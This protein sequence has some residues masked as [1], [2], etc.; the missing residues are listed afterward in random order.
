MNETEMMEK[1]LRKVYGDPSTED[2]QKR[3]ETVKA[4]Y[5]K[6][7]PGFATTILDF[8]EKIG[9]DVETAGINKSTIYI[10]ENFLKY[11]PMREMAGI[12]THEL[13]H[14]LLDHF[15]R[16][17]ENFELNNVAGDLAINTLIEDQLKSLLDNDLGIA[18]GWGMFKDFP[19][20]LSMEDY[21]KL[22][23][24]SNLKFE[25]IVVELGPHDGK[26][27]KQI[28]R[29]RIT[30][31]NGNTREVSINEIDK[32]L[33][34][35]IRDRIEEN[36]RKYGTGGHPELE[37]KIL[38]MISKCNWRAIL[39]KYIRNSKPLR[40]S[41]SWSRENRTSDLIAG[42]IKNKGSNIVVAIDVSGSMDNLITELI[43]E[44]K[45]ILK[46]EKEVS[47]IEAHDVVYKEYPLSSASRIKAIQTGGGTSFIP[48]LERAD[49]LRAD[50]VIY[51]TDLEGEFPK[52]T[53]KS[54]VIWVTYE[55]NKAEPPFGLKVEVPK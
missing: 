50:V 31:A 25:T 45:G 26:G 8:K 20:G 6:D 37:K 15:S 36:I 53:P 46:E 51:I 48:A 30:D 12:I 5:L 14:Y 44:L 43:G 28:K 39:K 13:M 4:F 16:G 47:V 42:R 52:W 7:N 54:K 3:W 19:K 18:P 33:A 40:R 49:Q 10:S 24:N 23:K 41:R 2:P 9:N 22:L 1:E 17:T 21:I 38:E 32:D 55:G 35:K 34:D 27:G 11:L 29:I